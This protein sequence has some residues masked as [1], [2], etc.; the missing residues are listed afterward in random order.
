MHGFN[1]TVHRLVDFPNNVS[2]TSGGVEGT[3]GRVEGLSGK[4]MLKGGTK[5]L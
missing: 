3:Q 4:V 1:L 2:E 5:S